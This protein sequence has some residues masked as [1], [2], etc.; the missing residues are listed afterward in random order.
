MLVQIQ[1]QSVY[2]LGLAVLSGMSVV[3]RITS[4]K[5]LYVFVFVFELNI[6]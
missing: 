4:Y 3:R 2:L 6:R 1:A 5:R